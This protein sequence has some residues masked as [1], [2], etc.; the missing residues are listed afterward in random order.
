MYHGWLLLKYIVQFVCP[1]W[2]RFRLWN[3]VRHSAQ[4][5][6]CFLGPSLSRSLFPT[7]SNHQTISGRR[8]A[9]GVRRNHKGKQCGGRARVSSFLCSETFS[10]MEWE[11]EEEDRCSGDSRLFLGIR[12]AVGIQHL[13][14][15]LS[16][17]NL[18]LIRWV[19]L[20]HT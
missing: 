7:P 8:E 13:T 19:F 4:C 18:S 20:S 3:F 12:L 2:P 1:C 15:P 5:A 14:C 16:K 6:R 10:V 9:D 17:H 11:G